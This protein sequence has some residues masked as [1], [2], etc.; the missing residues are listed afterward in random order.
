MGR[1]IA[2][3]P[4]RAARPRR[5]KRWPAVTLGVL[6]LVVVVGV[7]A[8]ALDARAAYA[9]LRRV[10]D[11]VT[12]VQEQVLAGDTDGA[13]TS[14]TA[15]QTDAAAARAHLHGPHWSLAGLLPWVGDDVRAVQVLSVA[16]D[17]L[18]SSALADLADVVGI[19][20]PSELAPVDGRV[21]LAPLLEVAPRVVAADA[22]VQAARESVADIDTDGLV[23]PLREPVGRLTAKLDEVGALT[24]TASRAVQLIPPMM[25]ADGPREYLMLVQN[26]SEPRATGGLTGSWVVI[27]ADG[28]RVELVDQRSAVEIGAFAEPVVELDRG[29]RGLYGTQLGRYPGNVSSTPDF[30]RTAEIAREMWR[31]ETGSEVDGVLSIDPVGLGILLGATGPVTLPSGQELSAENAS[32]LLLNQVYLDVEDGRTQDAFFTAAAGAVFAAFTSGP[33]DPTALISALDE[34][35]DRGRLMIWSAAE[36][37]Q[38]L[39]TGTTLSGDLRGNV[40]DSP[41]VGVYVHDRSAA[42]MGFY[43][44]LHADV[45][46]TE[47]FADGSQLLSVTVT[48]Q[49]QVPANAAEFP[50]LLNGGGIEIPAGNIRSDINVY[51]PTGGRILSATSD[52]PDAV[53]LTNFHDELQV[54]TYPLMLEPG[55][56]VALD[57]QIQT[58]PGLSGAPTVRV[59]P[60]PTVNQFSPSYSDNEG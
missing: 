29:E 27:R 5:R 10:A 43:E 45:V 7:A 9:E 26:N 37:E 11:G 44:H 56:T 24:A 33:V 54:G 13:A 57:L 1:R 19:L 34:T 55:D 38:A 49:S 36:Q 6:L 58:G 2:V 32:Q 22:S 31:L 30:P 51:A 25:G 46:S 47:Q 23:G 53:Y 4:G 16:G 40:G 52:D 42:K 17:D 8:L 28:G 39:L 35:A 48:V 21:D 12:T 18:A 41:I 20:D 3:E 50:R 59:T 14:V 60:G 15:L